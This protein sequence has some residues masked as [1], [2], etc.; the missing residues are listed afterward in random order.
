MH[1]KSCQFTEALELKSATY[2]S[3]TLLLTTRVLQGALQSGA[4]GFPPGTETQSKS[5]RHESS[6]SS[7]GMSQVS[8]PVAVVRTSEASGIEATSKGTEPQLPQRASGTKRESHAVA[9][10]A[11]H[12]A[13]LLSQAIVVPLL[14]AGLQ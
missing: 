3:A 14:A 8:E 11:F 9:C 5:V 13:W 2:R 4:Q 10:F 6:V 12:A 7:A 1:T